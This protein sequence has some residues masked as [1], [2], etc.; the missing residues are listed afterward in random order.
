M[1]VIPCA[2]PDLLSRAS[3]RIIRLIPHDVTRPAKSSRAHSRLAARGSFT[4][5]LPEKKHDRRT[6]LR[7]I[8][9]G[10]PRG[11]F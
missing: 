4:P 11:R 2:L 6:Y 5:W 3:C 9:C 7:G 8:G 1:H 10:P